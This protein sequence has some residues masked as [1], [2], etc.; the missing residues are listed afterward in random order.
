MEVFKFVSIDKDSRKPKYQQIVDSTITN[1]SN[2]H[3]SMEQKIPSINMLSEAF[4]LSRDTVEKAY[5]ILKER[6]IITSIRGKGFYIARTQLISK[7]NNLI[8][9]NKPSSYKMQIYNSFIERIG[10]SAHTDLN[11]YHCDQSLF[12]NLL[13]KY[14]NAYD[15]YIIMPHFK[16]DKLEHKSSNDEIIKELQKIPKEKLLI[17]DNRLT[18]EKEHRGVY[19]DFENDIY[20]ALNEGLEKIQKYKR[21]ILAYPTKSV[22]PYPKRI[23]FGFRKFCVQHNINFEILD[24]IFEDMILKKGDLFIT[25][26]ESDLVNLINLIRENEYALGEDIGVISYNETPLK[27]LLGITVIS[28]DF[29]QMGAT[30]ADMIL[31][32]Q[33]GF[34]K[35]P[36][37]FIDRNSI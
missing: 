17:I 1:I 3:L 20:N 33:E 25:I 24:E 4:D 28:T 26:Q 30:A 32:K 7:I 23:L 21:L 19:Q 11:I 8:L 13:K 10:A 22:Y 6:K 12:L 36:F 14:R 34:I 27:E 31:N 16:T 15:Y 5:N 18:V 35:N 2:G 29:K 37:R 9:I